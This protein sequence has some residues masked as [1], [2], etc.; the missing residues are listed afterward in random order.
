MNSRLYPSRRTARR[1]HVPAAAVVLTAAAVLS[2]A[3][4]HHAPAADPVTPH[5]VATPNSPS[6]RPQ[7]PSATTEAAAGK[8]IATADNRPGEPSHLAGPVVRLP[9]GGTARLVRRDVGPDGTLPVPDSVGEAAWWGVSMDA[10][11]G[12][13]VLAGHVDWQSASGPFAEL[14]RAEPG[15][16]LDVVDEHGQTRRYRIGEVHTLSKDDLP[17]R[18]PT[19][20]GEEGPHRVVLVTCGGRWLGGKIGYEFN[21]IVTAYPN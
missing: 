3:L 4:S 21:R 19:L 2:L 18:A 14:W 1:G 9:Q 16:S 11:S 6:L 8:G 5:A 12:A 13:V 20:F 7:E 15:E 10:R 17:Q